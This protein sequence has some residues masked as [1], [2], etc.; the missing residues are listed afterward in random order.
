MTAGRTARA[1][2]RDELTLRIRDE[3]RRQ[4]ADAGAGGLS[5]RAVAREL[6]MVSSALYRYFPRRDD[7]L[8]ALITDAYDS[9]GDAVEAADA[10][11]PADAR[12]ARW[13][14]ACQAVRTWAKG[15]PH[16]YALVYGSPVPGYQA[17]QTTIAPA[18]R[19]PLVLVG[20]V[21]DGTGRDGTVRGGT[22]RGVGRVPDEPLTPVLA[23]QVHALA[24]LVAPGMP[25]P[26]VARALMVWAQLF[27]LV[28]F[29]LF[30]QFVGSV[31]PSDEFFAHAVEQMADD[32]GL[33]ATDPDVPSERPAHAQPA[34]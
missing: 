7:L 16:E 34:P 9:L 32:L 28:S 24:D 26:L 10:A 23:D 21:R 5:L 20:I 33:A 14:A 8:T 22:G 30:G 6:G 17:P 25:G 15:R 13:R 3:A 18:A 19:V 4:L 27:G 12:R 31:D 2:A 1:I 29:E 11:H